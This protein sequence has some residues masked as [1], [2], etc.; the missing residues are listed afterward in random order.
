M[1]Q[2]SEYASDISW[3]YS[4]ILPTIQAG[5]YLLKVDNRN[6]RRKYEVCLKLTIKTP[7]WCHDSLFFNKV[8]GWY[9]RRFYEKTLTRR[10]S[11][12]IIVNFD[13]VFAS[14]NVSIFVRWELFQ[15]SLPPNR[16]W[17]DPGLMPII[18]DQYWW[19]WSTEIKKIDK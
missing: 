5:I 12:G 4:R 16:S 14:W 13:H 9:M 18:V 1:Y 19:N 11:I 15:K 7:E 10:R 17:Y 3:K 2:G 6:T 8:A